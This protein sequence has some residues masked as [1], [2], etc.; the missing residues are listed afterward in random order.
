[1]Q[2]T[3]N[4]V[5]RLPRLGP[6][7]RVGLGLAAI[8]VSCILIL[9]FA[10]NIFPDKTD[11]VREQRARVSEQLAT[12][13]S[14]LLET[15]ASDALNVAMSRW[16][17]NEDDVLSVAVRG[18]D[19][20]IVA[21]AGAH[22]QHW[23]PTKGGASTLQHVNVPLMQ[24]DRR[25]GWFEVSF[26]PA[27][28]TSIG[29]WLT[30]PWFI[31]VLTLGLGGFVLFSLYLRRVFDYLDP[32]AVLPDRIRAAFDAFSEGVM[33]IDPSGRVIL[34]NATIRE[35]FNKDGAN[36]VGRPVRKIELLNSALPARTEDHPWMRAINQRSPVRGEYIELEEMD[37]TLRKLTVNCSP[38]MD[39]DGGARGCITTFSD[40]TEIESLNRQ[41]VDALEELKA[42]RE[43][44][45]ARNK[46]LRDMAMHDVLTGG[47]NRRAFFEAV[48]PA[49]QA[50]RHGGQRLTCIMVDVDHFKSFNDRFGHAVG[51]QVLKV[52]AQILHG[53]VR[54]GDVLCRYGGEE[55]CM[56]MPQSGMDEAERVAERLRAAIESTAGKSVRG[57]Q[58]VQVTASFGIA[59]FDKHENYEDLIKDADRALYVAKDEGRNRVKR[60]DSSMDAVT[61]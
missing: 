40:I 11:G 21:Q 30:Q 32:Q 22:Q 59:E 45:E 49:F 15:T 29:Q 44:T 42:A 50:A 43:E 24:G 51:D 47:L 2:L 10:F 41:L 12:Q 38:V 20:R 34:A 33:V 60:Y 56:L 8:I 58:G 27:G 55:F 18:E 46:A 3:H 25:W 9:D 53:G 35:W 61:A 39:P 4:R 54:S 1:M 13:A 23:R 6:A 31:V 5:F 36:I 17:L 19:G 16:I 52:V 28:P 48:E 7:E 37:G 14:V 57:A 26:S